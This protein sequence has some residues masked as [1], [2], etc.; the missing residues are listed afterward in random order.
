[1]IVMSVMELCG[2]DERTLIVLEDVEHRYRLT[3]YT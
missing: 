2:S 1:M 3:F